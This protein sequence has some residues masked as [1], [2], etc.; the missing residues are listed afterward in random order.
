[1]NIVLS[2]LNSKFIHSSLALRYLRAYG[3]TRGQAYEIVEYTINMPVLDIISD[4]TEHEADVIG[5]ACYIWNI[6][7]TLHVASLL[8][9]IKPELTIVLGG[10]EVSYTARRILERHPY[11]DYIVQGEGEEVFTNFV[12][13]L[14]AGRS[15]FE[16]SVEGLLG[17]NRMT[18]TIEGSET[19]AEVK[20]LST[21]PFPYEEGD[22]DDL[23]HK[24]MYYESSRGCPFSCQYCLSGNANTVRFF[25]LERTLE[26]LQWFI[27][28]KVKQ[29]KFVDR[30]F[31]CAA[32]H[33]IPIMEWISAADTATNFHLEMEPVLMGPKE[34][35]L[36]SNSPKGRMQIEV[37]VQST[38]PD[39]LKAI[40]RYNNWPHICEV[41]EPVI[42][43]GR[44][45]VHMDLIIGLPHEHY[46]RFGQSFNDV[47]A[48]QPH[49]LQLGFL[50]LLQGSGLE[51]SS[52]FNYV[53]DS[54]A[55]YEVLASHVM[56]YEQIRFLKHL[57]DVFERFYNS[58]RL[59]TVFDYLGQRLINEK[60]SPFH[61]FEAMTKA[62]LGQN[63]HQRKL[64]DKDQMA[65]LYSFFGDLNDVTS[66]ELL[67]Y[68][69][70]VS[71]KGKV[72]GDELGLPKQTKEL[73]QAGEAFWRDEAV[74]SQYIPHYRFVEWRRIRQDYCEHVVHLETAY[75]LGAITA[76][77][78]VNL[79][80]AGH[81]TVTL[82]IDV[83][84]RQAP[85]VRPV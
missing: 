34:V 27:D 5:F 28:H 74:V 77:E 63:L 58:E 79:E 17:R 43:A 4:I 32:H 57:E 35:E 38:N 41:I 10:P 13:R 47:F 45:H 23:E 25:P 66:Q 21:I 70:L 31:N 7:M 2:T 26:E 65:F 49:A 60:E 33:H 39:T 44:T 82:I 67:Q 11:I 8:K 19:V 52:E 64:N 42:R 30:T 75:I 6:D 22:M 84:E 16:P 24:I 85:F 71:Y 55:P 80:A 37:G 73:L 29:I 1:M 18:D 9:S 46:E 36:L 40:K 59:R 50:K 83:K 72:R 14:Q 69:C 54:K 61:Y 3:R 20:D 48:L 53:Y 12:E 56:P 81:D 76:A 51:R 78:R 15:P 68:D 62:W